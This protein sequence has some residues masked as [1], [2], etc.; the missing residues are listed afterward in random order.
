M[1]MILITNCKPKKV[2]RLDSIDPEDLN[3]DLEAVL[4]WS[5]NNK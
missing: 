3:V 4:R 5:E 1:R 2:V